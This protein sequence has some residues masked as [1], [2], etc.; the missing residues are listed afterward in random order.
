VLASFKRSIPSIFFSKHHSPTV[1]PN[2]NDYLRD[3]KFVA[4]VD[5]WSLFR[6]S[7]MLNK[8]KMGPQNG[9]CSEHVVVIWSW[10]VTQV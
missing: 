8:L 1:I 7:F 5:K 9:G 6:K 2:N 10:L 3:T 4:V